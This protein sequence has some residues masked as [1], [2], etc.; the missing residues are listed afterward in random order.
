MPG[1]IA[2][3]GV[4]IDSP[5][6]GE[7]IGTSSPCTATVSLSAA[8][9]I[10]RPE[11]QADWYLAL[12]VSESTWQDSGVDVDGDGLLR[13]PEDSILE[14]EIE[15]ALALVRALDPATSRVAVISFHRSASL[16]QALTA[17]LATAEA[18]LIAMRGRRPQHG[19]EFVPALNAVRAEALARGDIPGRRQHAFF[20]SDGQPEESFVDVWL[21]AIELRDLPMT[22]D[23]VNLGPFDSPELLCIAESTSGVAAEPDLPG[24]VIDLLP[25]WLPP[26]H[27]VALINETTGESGVVSLDEETGALTGEAPAVA[28]PNQLLLQVLTRDSAP[29]SLACRIEVELV[30]ELDAEAGPDLAGCESRPVPLDASSSFVGA[31]DAPQYRWRDCWGRTIRGWSE[32]PVVWVR[33]CGRCELFSLDVRCGE[34]DCVETDE[35]LVTCG[36]EPPPP[37]TELRVEASANG[38]RFR[39]TSLPDADDHALG[40]GRLDEL[41]HHRLL[42]AVVD[43]TADAGACSTGGESEW[44]DFDDLDEAGSFYYLV[45]ARNDCAGDGA[46]ADGSHA[47][48]PELVRAGGC[49]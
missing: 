22:V 30:T 15:A 3:I 6:P 24:D 25:T 7:R 13:E 42:R 34:E 21:A 28:G 9:T 48:R 39:W 4:S 31:C 11:L 29:V 45:A 46:L 16:E 10:E 1:G 38:L 35:V 27:R 33:P 32:D 40:R 49:P 20:L 17:D 44:T 26:G 47:P 2:R 12:D 18:A 36:V 19:T 37:L 43:A 5:L 14:A 23:T 8:V 41:W